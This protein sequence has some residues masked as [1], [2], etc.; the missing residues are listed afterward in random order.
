MASPPL[1]R[2]R[3]GSVAQQADL[4]SIVEAVV[5]RLTSAGL[6]GATAAPPTEPPEE[7]PCVAF[8]VQ[9]GPSRAQQR[10]WLEELRSQQQSS[11][12]FGPREREEVRAL[13]II[14]DGGGPPAEH[15]AWFWGRVRL[16]LIVAHHG[17]A[18]AISDAQHADMDRLGIRLSAPAVSPAAPPPPIAESCSRGGRPSRPSGLRPPPRRAS[19][20][21]TARRQD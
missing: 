13:L 21:A 18:A 16:M 7:K 5:A 15:S 1:T 11:P 4:E 12:R 20:S 10:V 14:G 17:W 3:S 2:A 19:S 8:D 9:T 6:I